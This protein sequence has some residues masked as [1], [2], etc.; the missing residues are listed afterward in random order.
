MPQSGTQIKSDLKADLDA[1]VVGAG[2]AGLYMLHRLRLLGLRARVFEAAENVG[3]TWYFNR[4]PG[5]RCDAE[6]LVYSYSFSEDIQNEW[7]WTERYATQPEILRYLN[8][9]AD[10]LDLRRDIQFKTRVTSAAFEESANLWRIESNH[11]TRVTA[12]FCIL[13]TG[14]LSVGKLPEIAGLD[15]FAGPHYHTGAWP[16]HPVDFTGKRVG[17]IGTGSSGIQAI[18]VIAKQAAHL[19]VFQRTPN[20]S[21][22]AGNAPLSA[23]FLRK[24][25]ESRVVYRDRCRHGMIAGGGDLAMTDAERTPIAKSALAIS[26]EERNR[27]YERRWRHGGAQLIQ[28][29]PDIMLNEAANATGAEFVRSKIH[30]IVKDAQVAAMLCPTDYP[31]GSKRIC[32]DTEY[33]ETFNRQNVTLVDLRTTPIEAITPQGVRTTRT[34]YPLDAIVFATGFDAMTGALLAIDIRGSA[35][36]S[37][38]DVWAAGPRTY[39]GLMIASFPNLFTITGPGSPSV[40]SNVVVSIEQH[41]EWITDCL[42]QMRQRGLGRIDADQSAQDAWVEHVNQAA[43]AT[44]FSKGNSWYLGANI[45]GKPR[46]FMP[47]VGGVGPYRD[48]C[49]KVAEKGYE[50]FIFSESP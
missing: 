33:F 4:Y 38:R 16:H 18:P 40:L 6:S 49:N 12:Q 11:G 39:L 17:V 47:Y 5:A 35:G 1:L 30:S 13:A 3:G 42:A 41:V 10:R 32:V 50:G 19:T 23:D 25:N 31:L 7:S 9:V 44:L 26:T 24:F 20:F 8:F 34:E 14:C 48:T 21:V 36:I 46:V 27:E 29:F 43:N 45:P 2:F 22:P 28:A 15:R 37:L